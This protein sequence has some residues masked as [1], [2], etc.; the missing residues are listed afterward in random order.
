[1]RD[2]RHELMHQ[3]KGQH[4]AHTTV[5]GLDGSGTWSC[6]SLAH[7]MLVLVGAL[8]APVRDR[9]ASLLVG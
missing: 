7:G 5:D 1:M 8:R 2:H 9:T 6:L 4:D 3:Q